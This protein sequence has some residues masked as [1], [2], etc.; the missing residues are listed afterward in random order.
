MVKEGKADTT[1][2][3]TKWREVGLLISVMDVRYGCPLWI[4]VI[5]C[6]GGLHSFYHLLYFTVTLFIMFL[7]SQ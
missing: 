4:V 5:E 6:Q 3:A 1:S 2:L 7:S